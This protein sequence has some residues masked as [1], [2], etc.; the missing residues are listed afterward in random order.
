MICKL[1]K[2]KN[3]SDVPGH[4]FFNLGEGAEQIVLCV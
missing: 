3:A 4:F 2:T 1:I